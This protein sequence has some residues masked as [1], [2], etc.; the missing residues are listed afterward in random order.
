MSKFYDF[1]IYLPTDKP[2][3]VKQIGHHF[4]ADKPFTETFFCILQQEVDQ[5][6]IVDLLNRLYSFASEVQ[7]NSYGDNFVGYTNAYPVVYGQKTK[8]QLILYFTGSNEK[9]GFTYKGKQFS[10]QELIQLIAKEDE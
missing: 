4:Y 5:R 2:D 10:V 8:D 7:F 6:D 1:A 9:R 3:L